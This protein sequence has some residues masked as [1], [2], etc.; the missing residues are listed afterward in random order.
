MVEPAAAES[1]WQDA[2]TA[3][4]TTTD[5]LLNDIEGADDEDEGDDVDL[6]GPGDD[7]ND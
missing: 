3:A 5:E 4:D 6:T 7:W 2:F 1:G